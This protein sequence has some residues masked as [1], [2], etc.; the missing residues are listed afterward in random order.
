MLGNTLK[1]R[2]SLEISA[3]P[4]MGAYFGNASPYTLS[5]M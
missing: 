2:C 5:Y 4:C 3:P 1:A